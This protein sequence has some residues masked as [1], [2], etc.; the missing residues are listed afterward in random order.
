MARGVHHRSARDRSH[1]PPPAAWR[2]GHLEP[3]AAAGNGRDGRG[4]GVSTDDTRC[5]G[6]D[7]GRSATLGSAGAGAPA[8]DVDRAIAAAMGATPAFRL[9][10]ALLPAG[11]SDPAR[12]LLVP[13][14]A[15][16]VA[17][18]VTVAVDADGRVVSMQDPRAMR[19]PNWRCAG[20]TT[21]ISARGLV[22]CGVALLSS[23]DWC[24]RCSPSPGVRCGCFG[25]DA[26]RLRCSRAIEPTDF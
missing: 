24:C 18:M 9:R 13:P 7:R 23:P 15:D 21:C 11:G 22:R 3:R 2:V 20:D 19:S 26:A 16:G 5:A 25:S 17:A 10:A 6:S 12:V 4:A 1:V 8:V 14:G